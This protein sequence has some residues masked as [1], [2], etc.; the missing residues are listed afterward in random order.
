MSETTGSGLAAMPQGSGEKL[1]AIALT[2]WLCAGGGIVLIL[3]GAAF[4]MV[5]VLARALGQQ[6]TDIF[7]QARQGMDPLSA[8]LLDHFG[9]AAV[10]LLILGL[11]SLVIGV[12]FARFR[13][14]ARPAMELLAWA[15]LAGT[16]ILQAA[17]LALLSKSE[18]PQVPSSWAS[19]PAVSTALSILQVAVCLGVIRFVRSTAV[20]SAFRAGTAGKGRG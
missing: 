4:G 13:P 16:V 6:G 11:A 5:G 18:S 1:P 7:A 19:H 15:V 10:I 2:G 17:T 8:A 3:S 12:Q 9:A 20:R 14:A